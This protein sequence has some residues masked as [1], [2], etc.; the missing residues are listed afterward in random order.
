MM[1]CQGLR[2]H[3]VEIVENSNNAFMPVIIHAKTMMNPEKGM[4]GSR[5]K[6]ALFLSASF[7]YVHALNLLCFSRHIVRYAF[8]RIKKQDYRNDSPVCVFLICPLPE[9]CFQFVEDGPVA[10]H[11][12]ILVPVVIEVT[13]VPV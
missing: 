2:L 1:F 4:F 8:I 5:Q 7:C 10:V 3:F 9:Q 11:V 13:D 12:N 6:R